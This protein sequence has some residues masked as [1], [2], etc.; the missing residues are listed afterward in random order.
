ML[1][2]EERIQRRIGAIVLTKPQRYALWN[3]FIRDFPSWLTPTSRKS[4]HD[5][6]AI[7]VPTI[8]W[9]RF[10]AKVQPGPGCIMVPWRGML[11][12]IEKDGARKRAAFEN[13]HCNQRFHFI[14]TRCVNGEPDPEDFRSDHFAQYTWR[15]KKDRRHEST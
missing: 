9:K 13:A 10:R 14:V 15:L 8:Q 7:K 3:I 6:S 11:L 4:Y 2:R 5:G 12:G 1:T